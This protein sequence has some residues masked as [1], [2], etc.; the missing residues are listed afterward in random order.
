MAAFIG[1]LVILLGIFNQY[2]YGDVVGIE[3]YIAISLHPFIHV[4]SDS[5]YVHSN[6]HLVFLGPHPL[7]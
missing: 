1:H 5:F 3:L 2:N 6:S 4:V 7:Y